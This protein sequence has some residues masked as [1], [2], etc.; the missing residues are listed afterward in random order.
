[1]TESRETDGHQVTRY[2]RSCVTWVWLDARPHPE[3]APACPCSFAK[4]QGRQEQTTRP[5]QLQQPFARS[6]FDRLR[7]AP[8]PRLQ[9]HRHYYSRVLPQGLPPQQIQRLAVVRGSLCCLRLI[10]PFRTP[11][12]TAINPSSVLAQRAALETRLHH[13]LQA[14]YIDQ[15]TLSIAPA[16]HTYTH[17]V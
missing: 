14:L 7:T 6:T 17:N 10:H 3:G 13:P 5:K 4:E 1:M 8:P 16:S 9:R 12:S 2:H 15:S 11:N